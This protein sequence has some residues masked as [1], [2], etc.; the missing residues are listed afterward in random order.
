ML[1]K[2][3]KT[4]E[5]RLDFLDT[6]TNTLKGAIRCLEGSECLKKHRDLYKPIINLLAEHP[7]SIKEIANELKLSYSVTKQRLHRLLK[8]GLIK[9]GKRGVYALK[10][11]L[12][13]LGP[14]K[15]RMVSVNGAVRILKAASGRSTHLII[16][17]TAVVKAC[18]RGWAVINRE[19][20]IFILRRAD[21]SIGK[22]VQIQKKSGG[23]VSISLKQL[24]EHEKKLLKGGKTKRVLVG[25]YPEEWGIST[26]DVYSTEAKE[27]GQLAMSLSRWINVHKPLRHLGMKAD[28]MIDVN[29]QLKIPIEITKASTSKNRGGI[30]DYEILGRLYYLLKWVVE[31]RGPAFLVIS[32][33]WKH[34]SWLSREETYL[35]ERGVH[36]I[37]TNFRND[38]AVMVAKAILSII[39]STESFKGKHTDVWPR[40]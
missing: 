32:S 20:D 38:W 29:K 13:I 40:Y 25:F 30:K 3:K 18:R 24:T 19:D 34:H 17:N 36:I 12:P 15:G 10:G 4:K 35:K 28:L 21:S 22:R 27:D 5:T 33:N 16:Y 23:Y 39:K 7:L 9:R 31:K 6:Y 1:R 14:P 2:E 8:W 26:E 11:A 37:Y